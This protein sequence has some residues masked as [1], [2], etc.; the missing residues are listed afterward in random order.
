MFDPERKLSEETPQSPVGAVV[1]A[2]NRGIPPQEFHLV[3][4][5]RAGDMDAFSE[6]YALYQTR[7][8]R[9][10]YHLLGH[11]DDAD[12]IKQET[13][14]KAYQAIRSFRNDASLQT[15]LFKICGN[16]CRDR[17][18]S[19]EKRKVDYDGGVICETRQDDRL[20]ANPQEIVERAQTNEIVMCAL[21]GMPAA[22]RE[23]I[24][25]HELEDLSYAE[26]A[27]I[28]G[29]SSVSAKLRVF[30]ARRMLRERVQ[31]LSK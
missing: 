11:R 21:R 3:D 9:Y 28:L 4:R 2:Q 22:S 7:V 24:V 26:M 27:E 13:F 14:L 1:A 19:W 16:L 5:C 29:C 30:R 6:V 12:D 17:I 8:F 18:K 20:H 15:W 23:V 10:A 31:A 25:L